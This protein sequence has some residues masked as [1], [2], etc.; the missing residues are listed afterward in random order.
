MTEPKKNVLIGIVL[1]AFFGLVALGVWWGAS[2]PSTRDVASAPPGGG[3]ESVKLD[4]ADNAKQTRIQPEKTDGTYTVTDK[5]EKGIDINVQ[6]KSPFKM[7]LPTSLSDPVTVVLGGE[8]TIEIVQKDGA[9][10]THATEGK[11]AETTEN[12][13]LLS[14]IEKDPTLSTYVSSDGKKTI[15]YSYQKM[16]GEQKQWLFKNWILYNAQTNKTETVSYEMRNALV[17]ID[18]DG[19]AKVYFDDKTAI[20]NKT[21]EFT[22]PKPYIL[23]KNGSRTELA[24]Q[25]NESSRILSVSFTAS[26]SSYP[27]ALDPSILKTDTVIATFSGKVINMSFVCGATVWDIDGNIYDTVLI[28]TQCWMKENMMTT[29]YPD[30]TSITRG[31]TGATWV[32]D[33]AYYAYPPNVGN[34][35]EE[36]L[37]NIQANKLGFVY[38]W[39][40]VMKGSV[41]PGV[42]GICPTN[43]H[44]PTHDEYTTLERAVCTSGT[45]VTDFPIDI[46]TTGWRGTNEGSKLSLYTS[47]GNNSS[48]FSGILAGY[49]GTDGSFGDRGAGTS[50]WSSTPSGGNAWN[51]YLDSGS[52]AVGRNAG[53]KAYGFSVRCLKN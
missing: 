13:K 9:E 7:T 38:Q 45:C 8:R 36:S 41:T 23:D 18:T 15:F 14:I 46:T 44:V 49:R 48:G 27:I 37:A 53:A 1:L 16:E 34:T 31:P 11:S 50:L 30:G 47:G 24:W 20:G 17:A 22:I 5:K 10:Y 25:F 51:R 12:A 2:N 19:N 3:Q 29:K 32:G 42:Q 35:A 28:G 39:S 4:V 6:S 21:P 40:A 26:A 52:T 43:W 33:N